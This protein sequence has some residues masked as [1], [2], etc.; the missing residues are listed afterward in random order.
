MSRGL[1][2]GIDVAVVLC[3]DHIKQL[4]RLQP[5]F[6]SPILLEPYVTGAVNQIL[7]DPFPQEV[8]EG[9]PINLHLSVALPKRSGVWGPDKEEIALFG[10]QQHL[11]PIDHKH[12]I[13]SISDQISGMQVTVTDDGG[14][15]SRPEHPCQLFQGGEYRVNRGLMSHPGGADH[16]LN[17]TAVFS[18]DVLGLKGT[19][20]LHVL[21]GIKGLLSQ[22][23][24]ADR[25]QRHLVNLLE[26]GSQLLPLLVRHSRQT[27]LPGDPWIDDCG[28]LRQHGPQCPTAAAK[29]SYD[30]Y[31]ALIVEIARYQT[32]WFVERPRGDFEQIGHPRLAYRTIHPGVVIMSK[33]KKLQR[34]PAQIILLLQTDAKIFLCNP[35]W[36]SHSSAHSISPQNGSLDEPVKARQMGSSTS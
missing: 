31:D 33:R 11:I 21:A 23:L 29:R 1:I 25:W 13:R 20:P 16:T 12:L 3:Q 28:P 22:G 27:T 4:G 36:F 9:H 24:K 19:N 10:G 2:G 17:D 35:R 14:Q 5:T 8:G 26:A 7:H 30:R 34:D 32:A 6:F 15:G 18:M